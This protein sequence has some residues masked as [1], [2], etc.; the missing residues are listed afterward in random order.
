MSYKLG[1]E[2]AEFMAKQFAPKIQFVHLRNT[3]WLDDETFYESGHLD[4]NV[5]MYAVMKELL[6]EQKRRRLSGRSDAEMPL[7]PDHGVKILSDFHLNTHPGYPLVGRLKG[8]AE[9]T[10]LE[11]AIERELTENS[12]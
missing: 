3:R 6:K 4:G 12:Q 1:P 7:R 11:M 9:L 2:D 10:G 5:D 8:L